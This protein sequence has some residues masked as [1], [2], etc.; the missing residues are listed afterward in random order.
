MNRIFYIL[1]FFI[2]VCLADIKAVT[3]TASAGAS[4]A[5]ATWSQG[6]VPLSS[7]DVVINSGVNLTIGTAAACGS[8]TIGNATSSVTTLTIGAGGTL[9]ISGTTGNLRFNPSNVNQAFTLAV[10]A[11][12]LSVAGTVTFPTTNTATISVSTGT[13]IFST[14]VTLGA[15]DKITLTGT[16]TINFN[17]GLTDSAV[18]LTSFAGC[19]VNFGGS[20][21]VS[22]VAMVWSATA[23]T[24]FTGTSTITPTAAITFG[25]LQINSA[26]AVTLAGAVTVAG[27]WTN[28]GGTIAGVFD[29]TFSG[30]AKTIGGTSGT[31]FSGGIILAN[32]ATP[33][34]TTAL[35]YSATTLTINAG[36]TATSLTHG[37]TAVLNISG[38]VI[39]NQSTAAVTRAWNINAGSSTVSG[40]LSYVGTL[41]TA[42][43]ISRVVLTSGSLTANALSF[44]AN[45]TA[46]NQLL[47]LTTGSVTI[48]NPFTLA[49][50]TISL[51][52]TGTIN[53]NGLVT[54]TG[55]IV[56]ATAAGTYNFAGGYNLSTGTFTV[57]A[58]TETIKFGGNFTNSFAGGTIFNAAN[59]VVFTGNLIVTPTTAITFGNMQ[60]NAGVAVTLA[61]VI[62]V[63]GNWTNNGGTMA[64]AFDITFTGAGK[65][66]GGTSGTAFSKGI[67]LANAATYTLTTALTYS[68]T[69]FTISAGTNATSL[70]HAGTA[71]LNVSGNVTINQST[72]GVV[73]AWNINTGSST[74]SGTLSFIGVNAGANFISRVVL[75]SG[76]LTTNALSFD[77]NTTA[78]NQLL[79]LTTGSVT[80]TNPLTV[81]N[82]TISLTSTGTI[83]FSG[84]VTHTGGII[85]A[86]AAGTYNFAGGYNLSAGTFTVFAGAETI[87]FGG[88]FTNS[89]TGGTI[90]NAANTII[91]AGSSTVTPTTAITFGNVQI[92]AGVAVT[93]AG[94]VTVAGNWTNN[95]GTMAGAFDITFT[96]AAKTIGGTSGTAFSKGIILANAATYTLTTAFTYSATT[97]TINAGV[98]ATSLTHAGTAIFNISGGVVINQSTAAVTRAWNINA[99]SSTVSGTLTYTGVAPTV[100]FISQ[101]VVTSGSLTTNAISF[102][103]NA[104]N[105]NQVLSV[106]TG[107]IT[108]TNPFTLA[109]GTISLTNTGTINFTGLVTHTGGIIQATAAGTYNFAGGYNRSTGTFTVFAGAE[110]IKFGGSF[111]HSFAGGIIFNAANTIIFTGNSTVTPT[112]AITFGNVQVNSGVAVTLAGAVTVAGNWINNG[113]TM[114]GAF[115]ITFSGA[116]KTIGGTS[117]TAFSKGII[118]ADASTYTLNT[119][120]TFSATTF[121]INAG[122]TATSLTHAGTAILNISGAVT[123]NQS[124]AAVTRAWNINS[125]SSTVLG[126]LT[127]VGVTPTANFISRVVVT[128]GSLAVNA[129]SFAANATNANQVLSV[130]SGTVTIT[131]PYTLANGTI[132]LTNAGTINF[133]GFITHTGGII[134]NTGIAGTLNFAAGYNLSTGIFS[135]LAGETI[136]FGGNF[137]NSFAGGTILNATSTAVFT[138]ACTITPTTAI[139]FGN[140]QIN[141]GIA[142]TLTA[143]IPVAGNWTNN[144]GTIAGAFDIT[145]SGAAKIIGGTSGTVFPKGIILANAATYT[146]TTGLTYSATTFTIS[147]GNNATSLTHGGTAILNIS[148][149]VTLNQPGAAVTKAWNINAG[150]ST[151]SGN[152]LFTG[153][154]NTATRINQVAITSGSFTL[155]GNVTW[156]AQVGAA[157]AATEIISLTT[158][159]ITFSS[160]LAMPTGSGTL[161]VTSTGIINFNGAV[162]PSFNLDAAGTGVVD[163][164][165]ATASGCTLNFA[166][167]F[168]NATT[169]VV[170]NSGST[171]VFKGTASIT[172]T[173]AI[174]FGNLQINT[175][176]AVT[177][178]GNIS[179]AGNWVINGTGS[180]DALTN[181]TT[182]TFNGASPQTVSGTS[183]D[184]YNIN[185]ATGANVTIS[186]NQRLIVTLT[187]AGTGQFNANNHLTLVST[188]ANT[189]NIATLSTPA[190]FTGNITMQRYV[191]GAMGYRYIGS[192]ISGATLSGLTPELEID[193]MTGG[194]YPTYWCNVYTYNEPTAGAFSNGW[195][196]GTNVTNAMTAG[197]GFATYFYSINV[198]VTLDLNGPVNKGNQTLPVTF[199]NNANVDDGWNLVSNPYPS[200][201]DW[202]AVGWTRT[203]IQGNTYYSWN[204]AAQNY[205]SYPF[206]GPGVNSGTNIIASSQGFMVKTNAAG[207][208]LNMTESV[209][210][211]TNSTPQFW[212]IAATPNPYA[213]RLKLSG[214]ANTF[215]DESV[216]RFMTGALNTKDVDYD[217]VKLTSTNP[218]SPYL[219]TLSSDSLA[220]CVNS[221]PDLMNDIT[222]PI[223]LQAGA[224]GTYT[225]KVQLLNQFP[226][227]ACLVLEDLSNG[228]LKDVKVDSTYTFTQTTT[229]TPVKRFLLHVSPP[230][231]NVT[232]K[233]ISC[234]G[235]NNG[236]LIING[237]GSASWNYTVRDSLN[238]IIATAANA[239][240]PDTIFNLGKGKYSI[241]SSGTS[242]YCG[243]K[244]ETVTIKQPRP[245]FA[246]V[247]ATDITC[248]GTNDGTVLANSTG[249]SGSYFYQWSNGGTTQQI[250]NLTAGIYSVTVKDGNMCTTTSSS[251]VQEGTVVKAGFTVSSDTVYLYGVD[252]VQF[253]NTS[254]GANSFAWDFGDSATSFATGATHTYASLGNYIAKLY[255]Y[256]ANGCEDSTQYTIVVLQSV[257]L[258]LKTSKVE[259]DFRVY[260]SDGSIF[261]NHN[262]TTVDKMNI[263]VVNTMGQ[264]LFVSDSNKLQNSS[265]FKIDISSYSEGIYFVHIITDKDQ[266][267]K[268]INYTK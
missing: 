264:Q 33:T 6:H 84:L 4:W 22:G 244:S 7:E 267:T 76:S 32:A 179:V 259:D 109:N 143:A 178:A 205:A 108:I 102:A 71:V 211:S 69:T 217:A 20:Y 10:G 94:V 78:A 37:G 231:L 223:I 195:T 167:G 215:T 249:G 21:T 136:K 154:N 59:T 5:A 91:F 60:I 213:I 176:V 175:G 209:K 107:S 66:I 55:G 250:S 68:A 30:V 125:G 119:A 138:G 170:L 54:H 140:I 41:V 156:M 137:T 147:A 174:T 49:N 65:T 197:K 44:D 172:P 235:T 17:G 225:L 79:S 158:G 101:V 116:G 12:T 142:V 232:A 98:T 1:F 118:L 266:F 252:S 254:T 88:N 13:A 263:E 106:T 95:G 121:T 131:N 39:I 214:N 134:Q 53:F 146:L 83:N 222:I 251:S 129:I 220:L 126:T 173:A 14:A 110:T 157:P 238:T 199:T 36:A 141:S 11:R 204:D 153:N 86:T 34:L 216:V 268:K 261:I 262:S 227:S 246:S 144:G 180:V 27:N 113:G 120:L 257:P 135:T 203:N 163:A 130:T 240:K 16:G 114:A 122:A 123:I 61:G 31:A 193:G 52:S 81:A 15:S 255:A 96:G 236:S 124:T 253:S 162:A 221:L 58:G 67:I 73:R 64:G 82:G 19:T 245:M 159:T 241:T 9:T 149:D 207:P 51:T 97:F 77:A 155:T 152:L 248:A 92:N 90:F 230:L 42:N 183:T 258:A 229:S 117:G 166:K 160:S 35:T 99:G 128:T 233:D 168:T 145:F 260:T 80:I 115:D 165:F 50:G 24:V 45:T 100:N 247:I 182:I 200:S 133:N 188:A 218:A 237:N 28:N 2:A 18:G 38:N 202:D 212:K 47:S 87:K 210:S 181:T 164:V 127:C 150:S 111:T 46:A 26:V 104:T 187:L 40:T 63:A 161:Q 105:A 184:F 226:A 171:S 191:S 219:A 242:S 185:T 72:A 43:F 234:N 29:I 192:A 139:T 103:A 74:V 62:S 198:P 85:E 196:A 194:T 151:V 208:V 239:T 224:S 56:Q 201:I 148:G 8:L 265:T 243:T 93:L 89:F 189:A 177:L 256:S 190:N 25:N 70:T 206:G 169:A 112:T 23:N 48:T 75:T 57:F 186:S 228:T 3:N 132:S